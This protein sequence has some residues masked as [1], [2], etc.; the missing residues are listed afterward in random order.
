MAKK[1]QILKFR[2][3]AKEAGTDD[4]EE[5]FNATLK[6]LAKSSRETDKAGHNE[7]GDAEKPKHKQRLAVIEGCFGEPAAHSPSHQKPKSSWSGES[8]RLSG[9]YEER[10]ASRTHS[11]F[12]AFQRRYALTNM[13]FGPLP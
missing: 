7:P 12:P 8:R 5:R 3:A 9:C 2:E 11:R 1:T 13:S 6:D 10:C 4:S